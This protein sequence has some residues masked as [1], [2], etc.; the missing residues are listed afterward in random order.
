[1]AW[2]MAI[3][4]ARRALVRNPRLTLPVVA[5]LGLALGAA[6]AGFSLVHS[7]L[8]RPLPYR[9]PER[10]VM[11]WSTSPEL[12][13]P[14][15]V[16][17]PDYLDWRRTSRN[18]DLA[19]FKLA[20]EQLAAK[21]PERVEGAAVTGDFFRVLGVAPFAGRFFAPGDPERPEHGVVV[22]S[23]GLWRRRF[24]GNRAVLGSVVLLSGVPTQVIGIAPPGMR[25]PEPYPGVREA[26]FWGALSI[27][28]WMSVRH[29]PSLRV[30]YGWRPAR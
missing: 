1:M 24:G 19:A 3:G 11:V 2:L 29:P 26:E 7:I 27:Q 5:L 13:E 4:Q 18:L 28:S 20:E 23:H 21:E 9:A 22:L 10:L 30:V 15:Y 6:G 16:S 25:E 17:W 12:A 8:L 14:D